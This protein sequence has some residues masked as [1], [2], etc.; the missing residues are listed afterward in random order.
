MD[1]GLLNEVGVEVEEG[2]IKI[3]AK[4]KLF[5][6]SGSARIQSRSY[7]LL[8]KI[9]FF[10]K[11]TRYFLTIEGHT[12]NL[13][14]KGSAFPSNWELSSVRATT[15]LRFIALSGISRTR[16]RAIGYADSKPLVPNTSK[17]NRE[18]N[19]RVEFVFTKEDWN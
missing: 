4:V 5:F 11:K 14:A 12:D 3:R 1:E 7:E 8:K 6:G 10:M 13:P 18:K 16:L 19:R 2:K 15:V 9:S 17:R